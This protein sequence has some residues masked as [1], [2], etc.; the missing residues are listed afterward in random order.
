MHRIDTP[1]NAAEAPAP[2]TGM[3]NPGYWVSG[4]PQTGQIATSGDQ[5]WQNAAQEEL[6]AVIEDAGLTPTKGLWTGMR[7]ALHAKLA[8]Q[9][10][11]AI[12]F[13]TDTSGAA[14]QITAA[15]IS[16]TPANLAALAGELVLIEIANTTTLQAVNI[17]LGGFGNVPLFYP[18]GAS[19][20]A[21]GLVTSGS[22]LG[23]VYDPAPVNGNGGNPIYGLVGVFNAAPTTQRS[24]TYAGN[25]NTHVAG[26]AG[27][28]AGLPAD[29]CFDSTDK[30]WWTC[31]TTGNSA[32][33]VWTQEG[34]NLNVTE[35]VF[36]ASGVWNAPAGLICAYVEVQAPGGGGSANGQGGG[37]GGYTASLI[38]AA[39][40]GATKNVTIGAA[41]AAG[42]VTGGN[43]GN[44]SFGA[45]LVAAGGTGGGATEAAP[46]NGGGITTA[47]TVS[48]DGQGGG[49]A[50]NAQSGAVICGGGGDGH[51]GAGGA[52]ARNS[53]AGE[54]GHG[55][56][57]GGAG[58]TA[59]GGAGAPGFVRI[60]HY[61]G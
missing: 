52:Q 3:R 4:N 58:G 43:A 6:I 30:V 15:N 33:A 47:G 54:N 1:S 36:A 59:N 7:D 22:I 25:P 14:N 49:A 61:I 10:G 38:T 21:A 5:D 16:P 56:G 18:Q 34:G 40:L 20:P 28:P 44:A 31:T 29:R 19:E 41:G 35:Q 9:F 50:F 24:F 37:G 39:T 13:A 57:G 42:G 51:L 55:Y 46:G 8:A 45:L 12:F 2:L 11:A 26:H 32:G 27:S 60:T 17:N 48:I 23:V 53:A